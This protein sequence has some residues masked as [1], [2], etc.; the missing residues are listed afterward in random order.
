MPLWRRPRIVRVDG[1][2]I[3]EYTYT[4]LERE[5]R[6]SSGRISE[7]RVQMEQYPSSFRKDMIL[8]W[9]W[10]CRVVDARGWGGGT[11]HTLRAEEGV[12]REQLASFKRRVEQQP[13][14]KARYSNHTPLTRHFPSCPGTRQ[15]SET[16]SVYGLNVEFRGV[17]ALRMTTSTASIPIGRRGLGA[18][19]PGWIRMEMGSGTAGFGA[20][21][22]WSAQDTER[23]WRERGSK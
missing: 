23:V 9:A 18:I 2:K 17:R 10:L 12:R 20:S 5:M 14:P 4:P 3:R 13:A 7:L 1:R 21:M 8:T 11:W 6:G 15:R 16:D 19:D 22:R